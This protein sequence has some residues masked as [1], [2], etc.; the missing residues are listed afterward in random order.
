MAVGPAYVDIILTGEEAE[1][2]DTCSWRRRAQQAYEQPA[3]EDDQEHQDQVHDAHQDHD[4]DQVQD[5]DGGPEDREHGLPAADGDTAQS[6][7]VPLYKPA[8]HREEDE[9]TPRGRTAAVRQRSSPRSVSARTSSPTASPPI[10]R[11]HGW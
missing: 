6:D 4:E 1:L 2:T 7:P 10:R 3:D 11:W 8:P 5:H 9:P